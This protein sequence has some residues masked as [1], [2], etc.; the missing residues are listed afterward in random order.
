MSYF[1]PLLGLIVSTILLIPSYSKATPFDEGMRRILDDYLKIQ[2]T[3]AADSIFEITGVAKHIQ[4]ETAGLKKLASASQKELVGNMES[5]ANALKATADIKKARET[6]KQLSS[7]VAL[8][9]SQAKPQGVRIAFCPMAQAKWVQKEGPVRNPYYGK[10]ML[11]CGE[12][13]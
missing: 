2:S 5:S 9:A 10:E 12:F 13:E 3:L 6:F 8:W 4:I 1:K 11:E 7:A